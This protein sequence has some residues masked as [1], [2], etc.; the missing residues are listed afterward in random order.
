MQP[1]GS[2][3]AFWLLAPQGAV[4]L[5]PGRDLVIGRGSHV[6]VRIDD[7]SVSREHCRLRWDRERMWLAEDLA[8]SNGTIVAGQRITAA[9][10]LADGQDIV[11]GGRTLTFRILPAGVPPPILPGADERQTQEVGTQHGFSGVCKDLHGLVRAL[12]LA[13]QNGR[14]VLANSN[15]H[16]IWFI[17]GVP[18]A[19][20][21]DGELGMPA[22]F[23]LLRRSFKDFT[24]APEGEPPPN[25]RIDGDGETILFALYGG[26]LIANDEL[27]R[28][29]DLQRRLLGRLPEIPGW[30]LG[31]VFQ[32]IGRVSGDFYDAGLLADGR[33]MMAIGDVSGHGVRAAMLV[34]GLLKALRLIR[35]SESDPRIV[36]TRLN[37]DLHADVLPGSFATCCVVA[38]DPG[39]GAGEIILAGHHRALVRSD[40]GT[41]VPVGTPGLA[42]GVMSGEEFRSSLQSIPIALEPGDRLVL[43]TDGAFEARNDTGEELGQEGFSDLVSSCAAEPAEAFA[44]A[45]ENG[46][47]A[48]NPRVDDDLAILVVR[49][50]VRQDE[51]DSA[52][53]TTAV[54]LRR[55]L[56]AT[57]DTAAIALKLATATG[58]PP[59]PVA[60]PADL[61][62]RRFGPGGDLVLG[63]HLGGGGGGEVLAAI[64]RGL[65]RPVAVKRLAPHRRSAADLAKFISE[66]RVTARLD[67][68]H[69]VPIHELASDG[70]GGMLYVMKRLRGRNWLQRLRGLDLVENL[71]VLLKVCDAVAFAHERG[72]VHR[73]LKPGNILLGDHGEVLVTDWGLAACVRPGSDLAGVAPAPRDGVAVGSPAYMAPEQA[74]GEAAAIGTATDVYL[75]G[76]MLFEMI[77][78]LTPHHG[79]DQRSCITAAAENRIQE[80]PPGTDGPLLAIARAALASEP[81]ARPRDAAA[82]RARL[83]EHLRHRESLILAERARLLL[84]EAG[85]YS[86]CIRAIAAY[87]QSVALWE[88]N[89][90]A[91]LGLSAARVTFAGMALAR[92]DLDLAAAQVDP[93]DPSHQALAGRIADARNRRVA[94]EKA[95][96]RLRVL[97][98]N[99]KRDSNRIWETVY[100]YDPAAGLT[101]WDVISGTA[102]AG[103]QGLRMAGGEPRIVLLRRPISGDL[104]LDLVVSQ[105][106]PVV[107][108]ITILFAA[109]RPAGSN[110]EAAVRALETG[111]QFKFGAYDNTMSLLIRAGRRM[112]TRRM[113][114]L[115]PGRRLRITI[116]CVD[117][118]VVARC[119]G[120]LLCAELDPEPLLGRGHDCIGLVGW[121]AE[122]VVE[123]FRIER[124]GR[125][126]VVKLID[127]AR[128]HHHRG[129]WQTAADL[130]HDVIR[131]AAE[132][133]ERVEAEAAMIQVEAAARLGRRLPRLRSRLTATW[134]GCS[135]EQLGPALKV[136]ANELGVT[137]LAPLARLPVATLEI[138]RNTVADLAPIANPAL[139]TLFAQD[140][141]ISDLGALR[142][143]PLRALVLDRNRIHDLAP[144]TGMPLSRLEL[145]DCPVSD[146]APLTGCPLNRLMLDG[147]KVRNLAPLSRAPLTFLSVRNTA[148]TDLA[149][150]C[151]LQLGILYMEGCLI[152]DLAPLA[153]VPLHDLRWSGDQPL[154]LAQLAKMPL[155]RLSLLKCPWLADIA[156]LAGLQLVELDLTG[157]RLR[158]LTPLMGMP[159]DELYLADCPLASLA[160]LA[161]MPLR[162]LVI[163]GCPNLD[164]SPVAHL[165][166]T[167]PGVLVAPSA[168]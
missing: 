147:S 104:R 118:L 37:D 146:L 38:L 60:I 48:R 32:G 94:Q 49:R 70:E 62:I 92:G 122:S 69:I 167:E 83:R 144:L 73:D 128:R 75:L 61:P 50:L 54:A 76:G 162:R 11:I 2:S 3:I 4:R 90:Q 157:S 117:R 22:L 74:K 52:I 1:P 140:N 84:S 85:D 129:R 143:L 67:H 5:T 34:G 101:D 93:D 163:T 66:A 115:V 111:Y 19:A 64:Q 103:P 35:A 155:R 134:P 95:E 88:R 133:S 142:G 89:A 51:D 41:V 130:Y 102:V 148:I 58:Q 25:A 10:L 119:D 132:E 72:I 126:A 20:R 150:L 71:E 145:E 81:S 65:D 97:E 114:P 28:A 46:V 161:G 107:N 110:L 137:D 14:L 108:D 6:E 116:E 68:P 13:G 53:R 33:L 125:S 82:F 57:T 123:S 56:G 18:R 149:P 8:S 112:W 158:D 121:R 113:S 26:D 78:G 87:E 159:L 99:V 153:T 42:L 154:D 36:L 9:W 86:A 55:R 138:S 27:A 141:C 80:P 168:T 39:T 124:L 160:P 96:D 165:V 98:E 131:S 23:A 63:E 40:S 106:G 24:F 109:N 47:R 17:D 166:E 100:T 120:E 12:A 44:K 135:V 91:R 152:R 151:G 7:P 77:T 29:E 21:C 127:L 139:E 156:P 136:V 43:C 31:V 15:T 105:P 79:T 30:D 59:E 16:C 164:R 45:L